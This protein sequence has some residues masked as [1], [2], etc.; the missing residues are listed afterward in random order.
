MT[1]EQQF[2]FDLNGFL[3]I[4]NVLTLAECEA[5]KE[6]IYLM[7]FDSDKLPTEH[8]E[9][10]GGHFANLIDHPTLQP[11]L[12]KLLGHNIRLDHGFTIW[13]KKGERHPVDLHHGGPT[14]EPMFHYQFRGQK[15]YA[16]LLRV[17]FELNDVT[18]EDGGT[19]F[20]PGS[21][22]SNYHVPKSMISL[23][24]GEISPVIYRSSCKAGSVIIFSENVAHGGP[25][26]NNPNIPRVAVFYSYNHLGMQFHKPKFN[27]KIIQTLSPNQ[28]AYFREAWMYDFENNQPN[29]EINYSI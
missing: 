21:H 24:N 16:G 22:K 12:E 8:R 29:G 6:Q 23:N 27:P 17:V 18:I 7:K 15:I 28:Q 1:E 20:I 2:L 26:W 9:I 13:R 11:I 25:Q 10:P 4:D 19:C 5:L 3:I 14:P